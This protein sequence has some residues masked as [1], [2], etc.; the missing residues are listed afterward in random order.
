MAKHIW[1]PPDALSLEL[2]TRALQSPLQHESGCS[3]ATERSVSPTARPC[4]D[5]ASPRRHVLHVICFHGREGSHGTRGVF[6]EGETGRCLQ[7]TLQT[8]RGTRR[9][10]SHLRCM[11]SRLQP[12]ARS[13]GNSDK[14]KTTP[15]RLASTAPNVDQRTEASRRVQSIPAGN[16]PCTA[17]R[18]PNPRYTQGSEATSWR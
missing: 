2:L 13:V 3:G 16:D 15:T 12:Q 4:I 17:T 10:F 14:A 7:R 6:F 8:R 1:H 11:G 5:S 9:G 18:R